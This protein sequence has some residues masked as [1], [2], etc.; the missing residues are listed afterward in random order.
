M[1]TAEP[2]FMAGAPTHKVTVGIVGSSSLKHYA[3]I[4]HFRWLLL[5]VK[6]GQIVVDVRVKGGAGSALQTNFL[7][8]M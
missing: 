1:Y 4:C 7:P 2:I 8:L 5:T 6:E 3:E